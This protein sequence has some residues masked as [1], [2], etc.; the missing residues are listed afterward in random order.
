LRG[1]TAACALAQAI[2]KI[3]RPFGRFF[4]RAR[5]IYALKQFSAPL[6][7]LKRSKWLAAAPIYD[8]LL[9]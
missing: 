9:I 4:L 1:K 5:S 7:R 8:L 6:A 2:E 3:H